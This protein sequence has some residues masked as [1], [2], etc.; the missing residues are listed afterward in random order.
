MK[1]MKLYDQVER[2]HNELHAIGI[3]ET[4]PLRVSD[5]TPFDQYHYLGTAAVDEAARLLQIGPHM[6]VLEIGSGIGGP[7]RYLAATTGCRVV[8]LELQPD[9][10][11]TAQ[12]LTRRCGFDG[13]VRHVCGDILAQPPEGPYDAIIS[14]LVFLHIPDRERLFRI[15]HDV[16]KSG[17]EMFIEDFILIKRGSAQ[18]QEELR[19]KVLCPY[20]PEAATY[21]AD[22]RGAGFIVRKFVDMSAA[23]TEFTADR[24]QA[25][26]KARARNVA[27]HGGNITDGL[28]DF[29]NAVAGLFADGVVG[30][31][32]IHVRRPA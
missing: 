17:G 3:D 6:N 30:G 21:E 12:D 9:L 16:L 31:A 4:A 13:Q 23:W 26:R 25:F 14:F 32:R 27:L 1:S 10:H 28:D 29:Y 15:C 20:L 18:Q 7:A 8:A 19:T 2:I 5:L 24:L 11:K 22:L